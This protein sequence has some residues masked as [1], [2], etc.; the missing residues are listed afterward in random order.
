MAAR[1]VL[2]LCLCLIL[3]CARP[4]R[5]S[6]GALDKLTRNHQPFVLVFGSVSTP[7]GQLSHPVVRVVRQTSRAAPE[8]LLWSLNI[9]SGDR[10]FAVLKTPSELPYLDEF[11]VQ[12]GSADTGFDNVL[13]VRLRK[14]DA[15]LAMYVGEIRVTPAQNRNTQGQKL[16]ASLN[17][18]FANAERELKHLYPHF[19]ARITKA[20][21]LNHPLPRQEAPDR[22]K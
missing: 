2:F 16:T 10:F 14:D 1:T 21:L 9:T 22:V 3:S 13:F 6:R 7:P 15:P 4:N 19:E 12:V 8:Y 5:I 11:Y 18:D 20:A 17:D